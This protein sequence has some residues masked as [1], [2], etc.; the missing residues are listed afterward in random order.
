MNFMKQCFLIN[1]MH[2]FKVNK[3]VSGQS[4][5]TVASIMYG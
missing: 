5:D 1:T 4:F 3:N 2:H